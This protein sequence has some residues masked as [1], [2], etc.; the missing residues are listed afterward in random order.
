MTRRL[1]ILLTLGLCLLGGCGGD[2]GGV[3]CSLKNPITIDESPDQWPKFR[4][5]SQ[6]TGTI[7]LIAAAYDVVAAADRPQREAVWQFPR[8]DELA[9]GPFAGSA[10]LNSFSGDARRLYV[11][12]ANGV[13]Y[14]LNPIDGSRIETVVGNGVLFSITPASLT[15]TP[16]VGLRDGDDAVVVGTG[17]ARV[18]GVDEE[19]ILLNQVWPYLADSYVRTSPAMSTDGMM[20]IGSLGLGLAGVCPNGAPKFGIATGAAESSPAVGRDTDHRDD[21][22]FFIGNN[23]RNLRAI[24]R[25]GVIRWSFSMSAPIL[26]SPVV[27]LSPAR[28]RTVAVYVVDVSGLVS[29]VDG[30]GRPIRD[31]AFERG[32]IGRTESSPALAPHPTA[33]L[34]LYLGS[35]DGNLYAI[36]AMSGAVVWNFQTG[37]V[38]R[39]SPA[40]VLSGVS[41][42]DPI[43]IIGSFDGTLYYVRDT[44]TAPELVGTF[45]V[46]E[47]GSGQRAIESSPTVDRDG[48]VYFGA[49]NG[50]LYAVR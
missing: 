1:A 3:K 30:S 7:R 32:S 40:V 4:R 24:R 43:V 10:S 6:N 34:R 44:G 20:L 47:G 17:D 39:S 8:A 18:F 2:S 35:D 33:G 15:S 28:D 23:D 48:T 26:S 41:D 50:R 46:P 29:K 27:D 12:S 36:D 38:V 45:A 22:T 31:F 5:D 9:A 11:P 42:A 37:G 25:D 21:G 49:D 16:L 14:A 19:G 13:F